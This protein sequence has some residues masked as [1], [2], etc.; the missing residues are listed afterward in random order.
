MHRSS[1]RRA[2]RRNAARA[3]VA[4]IVGSSA[5]PRVRR[6]RRRSDQPIHSSSVPV[7]EYE[8]VI[9]RPTNHDEKAVF[10]EA[11]ERFDVSTKGK[12]KLNGAIGHVALEILRAFWNVVDFRTGRLEPS[13]SWIQEQT[14]R[15]RQAIAD[16]LVRLEEFGFI[17]YI[18]RYVYTGERGERG[19]QMQQATNAYQLAVPPLLALELVS[20]RKRHRLA[21]PPLPADFADDLQEREAQSKQYR[22]QEFDDTPTGQLFKKIEAGIAAREARRLRESTATGQTT[23]GSDSGHAPLRSTRRPAPA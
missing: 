3:M 10:L 23:P 8:H 17:K 16:A 6:E 9:W 11:A 20:K 2:R 1:L 5:L 13:Y 22:L 19:P 7:G 18:R 15:C 14:G 21:R 12:D 4:A